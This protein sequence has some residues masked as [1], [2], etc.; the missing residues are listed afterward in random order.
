MVQ[1]FGIEAANRT[2]IREINRI[3]LDYMTYEGIYKACDR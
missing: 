3:F 1:I 2:L